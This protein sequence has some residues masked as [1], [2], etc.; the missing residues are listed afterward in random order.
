MTSFARPTIQ[1][2]VDRDRADINGRLPGADSR[3]RRN[4]LD[5][6]ARVH[7]GAMDAAYGALDDTADQVIPDTADAA[8]LARWCGIWGVTPKTATAASGEVDLGGLDGEIVPA[9]SLL[10]RADLA[11]FVIAAATPIV[12]GAATVT[13]TA[14][15]AGVAGNT[16]AGSVLTFVSPANGVAATATVSTGG[17]TGGQDDEDEAALLGRL[18]ARIQ[19]PPQ[20]GSKKDYRDWAE[21]L[22][23]ITRAWVAPGW[24]GAGTVGLAIVADGRDDIIPTDEDIALIAAAIELSRPVTADVYVIAPAPA[25]TDY[26][27][28]ITPDTAANR[29]A[30]LA[31]LADLY[32]REASVG[33]MLVVK[34]DGSSAA[35][36]TLLISHIRQAIGDAGTV[37]DYDLQ[38]P[39][40]D[41][42]MAPG[43]IHALGTVTWI[44]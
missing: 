41:I 18:L 36:G 3:V 37:N 38:S 34:D 40:A 13:V 32:A 4:V 12:G 25:A 6:V 20:G 1:T 39:A 29:A 14:S 42:V 31:E 8:H 9:G 16:A 23:D 11:E 35:A 2:I 21:D 30:V 5:V 26:H 15:A 24:M 44:V 27:L 19:T 17:L 43:A 10:Q 7:S 28:R 22:L 33:G